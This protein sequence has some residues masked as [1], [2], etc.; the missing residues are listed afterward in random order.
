MNFNKDARTLLKLPAT[1]DFAIPRLPFRELTRADLL[2]YEYDS[3]S[4]ESPDIADRRDNLTSRQ[5]FHYLMSELA[6]I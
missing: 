1:E 5:I 3:N 4:L 2:S 6:Q